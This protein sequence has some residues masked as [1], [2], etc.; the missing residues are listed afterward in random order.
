MN[1]NDFSLNVFFVYLFSPVWMLVSPVISSHRIYRLISY[2]VCF[3]LFTVF[4][5]MCSLQAHNTGDFG[6]LVML[7]CLG[8][9]VFATVFATVLL[10][11]CVWKKK[12]SRFFYGVMISCAVVGFLGSIVV[13]QN[14]QGKGAGHHGPACLDD[15]VSRA[16]A[17]RGTD[18]AL[19]CRIRHDRGQVPVRQAYGELALLHTGVEGDGEPQGPRNQAA[20][21]KHLSRWP[22][23]T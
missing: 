16:Q 20:W 13:R 3:V 8:V 18:D 17:L 4:P 6:G 19:R 1:M 2:A 23:A 14:F 12:S 9:D 21:L 11:V 7:L 10:I 15:D 5:I 22:W